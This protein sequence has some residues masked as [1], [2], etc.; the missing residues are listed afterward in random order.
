MEQALKEHKRN[1]TR[2]ASIKVAELDIVFQTGTDCTSTE[3]ETC[4]IKNGVPSLG[5]EPLSLG[6]S[7]NFSSSSK[8]VRKEMSRW[9]LANGP[10]FCTLATT[11]EAY[12]Q[13]ASRSNINSWRVQCTG[14][15]ASS[16]ILSNVFSAFFAQCPDLRS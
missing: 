5:S 7:S 12:A 15:R 2:Q 13:T 1:A 14:C 11:S 3:I 10:K 4:C 9:V 16:M 8:Q 6:G